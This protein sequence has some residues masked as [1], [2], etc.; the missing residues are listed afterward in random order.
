MHDKIKRN[1]DLYFDKTKGE[2]EDVAMDD[3]HIE[4]EE[5][6]G[7]DSDDVDSNQEMVDD[8][9]E[10]REEVS[11]EKLDSLIAFLTALVDKLSSII[12]SVGVDFHYFKPISDY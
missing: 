6:D 10:V 5:S 9:R 3:E 11:K 8:D 4:E 12:K 2:L 1:Y 7:V